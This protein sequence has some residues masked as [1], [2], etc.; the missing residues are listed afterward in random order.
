M[1][2]FSHG[3][4]PHNEST[5][6]PCPHGRRTARCPSWSVNLQTPYAIPPLV[7][8]RKARGR[9]PFP[10]LLPGA[11]G[12]PPDDAS[13]LVILDPL[14]FIAAPLAP[15]LWI[16][17]LPSLP[18]PS[19]V[20]VP[21]VSVF[22]P[23]SQSSPSPLGSLLVPLPAHL[24]P[25]QLRTIYWL[26]NFHFPHIKHGKQTP[27]SREASARICMVSAHWAQSTK[28]IKYQHSSRYHWPTGSVH[29]MYTCAVPLY[30]TATCCYAARSIAGFLKLRREVHEAEKICL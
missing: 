9:V 28:H 13:P 15:F 26:P 23:P 16:A 18:P 17:S 27:H 3:P 29:Q 19:L 6:R 2:R 14:S 4:Q 30:Y 20:R 11:L 7:S 24:H 10:G 21:L 1:P 12:D 8:S 5:W 25:M 22:R